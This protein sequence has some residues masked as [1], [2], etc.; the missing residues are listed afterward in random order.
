MARRPQPTEVPSIA[1][2]VFRIKPYHY[3]HVLD[4]NNGVTNVIVGPRTFTRQV[5]IN[6]AFSI[7]FNKIFG[8]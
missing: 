7:H 1:G 5:S 3:I 2:S 8:H 4:T 6:N